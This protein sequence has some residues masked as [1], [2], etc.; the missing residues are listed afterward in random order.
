MHLGC[1]LVQVFWAEDRLF[2]CLKLLLLQKL[3]SA[4]VPTAV[5]GAPVNGVITE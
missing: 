5:G 2:G 4:L 1:G 3:A